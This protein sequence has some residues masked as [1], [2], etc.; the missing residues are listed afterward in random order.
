[1]GKTKKP[2]EFPSSKSNTADSSKERVLLCKAYKAGRSNAMLNNN[3]RGG[4]LGNKPCTLW[5][6]CSLH[7]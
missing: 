7:I 3:S 1:M 2:N 6:A 5:H 4:M